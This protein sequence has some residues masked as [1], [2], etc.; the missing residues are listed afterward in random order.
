MAGATASPSF[1]EARQPPITQVLVSLAKEK[2]KFS[3][4]ETEAIRNCSN[5]TK[6][7]GVEGF[8]A[9][10]AVWSATGSLKLMQRLIATLAGATT[11]AILMMKLSMT[12]C[13]EDILALEGSLVQERLAAI[14]QKELGHKRHIRTL[15]E[16]YY[17]IEPLYDDSGEGTPSAF[18]R[19]RE[20][21]GVGFEKLSK[22]A[23]HFGEDSDLLKT[24][25]K[26][27]TTPKELVEPASKELVKPA[28]KESVENVTIDNSQR[29]EAFEDF[30]GT[31]LRSEPEEESSKSKVSGKASQKP[32][33][34]MGVLERR[35]HNRVRYLQWQEKRN[36]SGWGDA[37]AEL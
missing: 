13:M 36:A 16:K 4:E 29:D 18:M 27:S 7:Y 24:L 1:S 14:L 30:F 32:K 11:G 15:L 6:T 12:P 22:E 8:L 19:K 31:L 26:V 28:P 17:Y 35:E 23:V 20:S 2:Y 10:C 21:A 33:A 25:N 5:R 34:R 37:Q 3:K 9:G